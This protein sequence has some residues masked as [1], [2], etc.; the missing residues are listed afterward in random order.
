MKLETAEKGV[1]SLGNSDA[2]DMI[3][4]DN[5]VMYEGWDYTKEAFNVDA[6]VSEFRSHMREDKEG[7]LGCD[8]PSGNQFSMVINSF[9]GFV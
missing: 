1:T 6:V 2:D 5:S 4:V 9:C 7:S 3:V 8:V